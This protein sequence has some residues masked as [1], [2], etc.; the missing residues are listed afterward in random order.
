MEIFNGIF[1]EGGTSAL[2]LTMAWNGKE[3]K[4]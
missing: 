3:E 1:Y 2:T 4:N